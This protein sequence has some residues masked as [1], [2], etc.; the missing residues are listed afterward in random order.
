MFKDFERNI[1]EIVK[2][3]NSPNREF[4]QATSSSSREREFC[5][6]TS[7]HTFFI[8]RNDIHA[9]TTAISRDF[10]RIARIGSLVEFNPEPRQFAT[11]A[12]TNTIGTF[13]DTSRKHDCIEPTQI[14][15]H[16]GD[17]L[18]TIEVQVP[19][20]VEGEALDAL[21]KFD[22]LTKD[23]DVRSEFIANAKS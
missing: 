14:G 3:K 6:V 12:V 15:E 9:H 21:K 18:V 5:R 7:N 4:F 16:V 1:T 11:D 20:R 17:L 19:R 10:E 2:N 22:E 8:S 13:T 23:N